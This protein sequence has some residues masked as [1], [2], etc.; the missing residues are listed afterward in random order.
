MPPF[1]NQFEDEPPQSPSGFQ[2]GNWMR[3]SDAGDRSQNFDYVARSNPAPIAH[4]ATASIPSFPQSQMLAQYYD[5]LPGPV[6]PQYISPEAAGYIGA[7][8]EA[9]AN[10]EFCSA[11]AR[12]LSEPM[13]VA[14]S[15]TL[16]LCIYRNKSDK[17]MSYRL[18]I[19]DSW[20]DQRFFEEMKRAYLT[21]LGGRWRR[22]LS[23]KG[24]KR[25]IPLHVSPLAIPFL[26]GPAH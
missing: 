11:A 6:Y 19:D 5:P 8:P 17:C 25:I 18:N 15:C 16:L 20:T 22:Y 4:S 9:P 13:E 26:R 2:D 24:L 3:N 10:Q 7:M 12:P 23:M 14:R 21:K 1:P